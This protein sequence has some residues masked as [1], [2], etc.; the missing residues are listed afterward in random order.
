MTES[1]MNA[2]QRGPMRCS[3]VDTELNTIVTQVWRLAGALLTSGMV[4]AQTWASSKGI[5]IGR[6]G[7]LLQLDV[8][9]LRGKCIELLQ[10][11]TFILL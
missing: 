5:P 2:V 8:K 3:G 9:L 7:L 10:H 1:E 11:P 6:G 4:S